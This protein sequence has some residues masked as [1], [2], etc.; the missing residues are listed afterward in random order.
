[1]RKIINGRLY[2]TA[3]STCLVKVEGEWGIKT[4]F[5]T[6]RETYILFDEYPKPNIFVIGDFLSAYCWAVAV[7]WI[8]AEKLDEL[9]GP[10]HEWS[11][12]VAV[13]PNFKNKSEIAFE[14]REMNG[15]YFLAISRSPWD[16]SKINEARIIGIRE[17]LMIF[18]EKYLD[19]DRYIQ[20]FGQMPEG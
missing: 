6:R 1:M 13:F 4:L 17:K 11:T 3:K 19:V 20:L 15:I 18:M 12:L 2:D 16:L 14:I 7:E 8:N 5:L 9:F 10:R